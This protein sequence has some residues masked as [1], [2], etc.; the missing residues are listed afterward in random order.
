MADLVFKNFAYSTLAVAAAAAD[1]TITVAEG[2]TFPDAPND[3]EFVVVL[4][5]TNANREIARCTSRAGN[6]LTVV[7]AQEGTP[8]Q[9]FPFGSQVELR[10]TSE[11]MDEYFA[12]RGYDGGYWETGSGGASRLSWQMR[13]NLVDP[14]NVPD[15]MYE[16]EIAVNLANSVPLLFMGPSGGDNDGVGIPIIPLVYSD[17]QPANPFDRL[18]WMTETS[19]V[20]QLYSASQGSWQNIT[21]SDVEGAYA[22]Q[23]QVDEIDTR[24]TTLEGAL[25]AP[26]GTKMVFAQASAPTGWVQ[27]AS[28]NDRML[29]VVNTAGGGTGGSWGI[30]G[31]TVG[32]HALTLAEMPAHDHGGGVHTHSP[33]ENIAVFSNSSYGGDRPN[34]IRYEFQSVPIPASAAIISSQGSGAS[35]THPV[36]GDTSTWRP[37]YLDIIVATKS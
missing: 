14:C 37:S 18:L 8:A 33:I 32:G 5:D 23:S 25:T 2:S 6:I 26:A 13:R 24:V 20:L 35:H 28:H 16:G 11:S 4:E 17:T 34:L 15:D 9:D 10:Y 22:S 27:D 7:R 31:L 30:T 29:R 3:G 21:V 1:L 12:R 36:S 19:K